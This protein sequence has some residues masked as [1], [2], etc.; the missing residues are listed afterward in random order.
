LLR[1]QREVN[2]RRRRRGKTLQFVGVV[3]GEE[4]TLIV[5]ADSAETD[6]A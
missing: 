3:A 1:L 6:A 5:E 2:H 4:P